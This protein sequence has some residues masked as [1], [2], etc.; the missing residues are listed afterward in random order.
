LPKFAASGFTFLSFVFAT[1]QSFAAY[2]VVAVSNGGTI[3][4]IVKLSAAAPQVT[5]IKTTKNQDYC[6]NSIENPLYVVGN[7]A[8]VANVEVFIKKIDQGKANPTGTI[9]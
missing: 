8:G 9:T 3:S 4:G 5:P 7:D 2:Q 1:S 6:G